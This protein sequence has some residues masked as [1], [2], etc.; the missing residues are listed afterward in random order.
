MI[1]ALPIVADAASTLLFVL[2]GSVAI[3]SL[4]ARANGARPRRVAVVALAVG[5]CTALQVLD[6][7]TL[8]KAGA[9]ASETLPV[10][11]LGV[12]VATAAILLRLLPT[13]TLLESDELA[14]RVRASDRRYHALADALP[15]MVGIFDAQG[16]I[17]FANRSWAQFTNTVDG[18]HGDFS[19]KLLHPEDAGA[20]SLLLRALATERDACGELRLRRHDGTYCR[21]TAR[22]IAL[23]DAAPHDANVLFILTDI[24]RWVAA[25][26]AADA[27]HEAQSEFFLELRQTIR[28]PLDGILGN[29]TLLLQSE[30]TDEQRDRLLEQHSAASLVIAAIDD[31]TESPALGTG[32]RQ[33]SAT[34]RLDNQAC[35]T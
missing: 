33:E 22:F 25:A 16:S 7:W 32:M 8:W 9:G 14:K 29:S 3:Q 12:V 35:Q 19:V 31:L 23:E 2:L 1:S 27:A 4:P 5:A 17:L 30:L 13:A 24:D 20:A 18:E 28:T 15:D 26:D 34:L 6:V 11:R 10:V 21:Y